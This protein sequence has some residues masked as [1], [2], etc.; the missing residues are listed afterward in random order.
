MKSG[1]IQG[2]WIGYLKTA[3]PKDAPEYLLTVSEH[4]FFAGAGVLFAYILNAAGECDEAAEAR[5][6]EIMRAV[7]TE[8]EERGFDIPG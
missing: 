3:I 5:T 1:V 2:L 6:E 4:A 8:L 7:K